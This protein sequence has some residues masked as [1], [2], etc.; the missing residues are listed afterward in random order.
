MVFPRPG[1]IAEIVRE[2]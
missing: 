2:I 1:E